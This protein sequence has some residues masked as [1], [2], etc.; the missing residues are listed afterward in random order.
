MLSRVADSIYWIARYVERA[1]HLARFIDVTREFVLDLPSGKDQWLP[2]ILVTGDESLF[3]DRFDTADADSVI[4]FLTIDKQYVG[5]IIC[6]LD[7][8]RENARSVRETIASEMWEQINDFY[9][10]FHDESRGNGMLMREP[11][12]FYRIVMQQCMLFHGITDATMSRGLGWHFANLGRQLERADK[13]GRLLDVKYFTLL[14]KVQDVNTPLD[15]MQWSTLLR[16]V[17]G[18]EMYRKRYQEIEVRHV[19]DF[20]V[21]DRLFPRS[22]QYCLFEAER[23]LHAITGC[24]IGAFSCR[25]EQLLG[26]LCADMS[27]TEIDT[28]IES[29][30]HEFIDDFQAQLNQVGDAVFDRFFAVSPTAEPKNE[31]QEYSGDIS[32]EL[33]KQSH[34]QRNL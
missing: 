21:L 31:L 1:D 11:G 24:P 34:L 3:F 9:H 15:N 17:S 30:L 4:K 16:S 32:P 12:D 2:L 25:S 6:S 26:R 7:Q 20:L 29:G 8:A 13:I 28:I 5:S 14:P 10:W 18:F 33:L 27:Y 23:S 19:V 22:V